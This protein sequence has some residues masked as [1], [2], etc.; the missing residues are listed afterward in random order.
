MK[1]KLLYPLLVCTMLSFS[2]CGQSEKVEKT[3]VTV[4][5]IPESEDAI[6]ESE[7]SDTKAADTETQESETTSSEAATD[8]LDTSEQS[9]DVQIE[10]KTA[11]DNV[12]DE[13][14]TVL[15]VKSY[16]YPIVTIAGNEAA[17]E[18]INA[19]I[20]A[21]IDAFV[22]DTSSADYA[23]EDRQFRLDS[24]DESLWNIL[25]IFPMK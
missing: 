8:N 4:E 11:E 23:K 20:Q 22:A 12:T 19:D 21:K 14:G 9:S 15:L 10:M 6:S 7:T 3:E 13:D 17:A 16:T 5:E 2:A 24:G 1:K 25:R 18:K